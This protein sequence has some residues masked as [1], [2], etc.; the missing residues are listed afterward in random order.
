VL[1]FDSVSQL[2]TEKELTSNVG[3]QHRAPGAKLMANF[4]RQMS[5]T[6][7][8]NDSVVI[9][10]IHLIANTSGFGASKVES[11]GNKIR[12]ACDVGIRAKK[13][14]FK[15]PTSKKDAESTSPPYGQ[16]VTWITTSTAICSPGQQITSYIRYGLG[17]DDTFEIMTLATDAGLIEKKGSWYII[18]V[19]KDTVR[20]QG[21]EKMCQM[22][23]DD[24]KLCD[25]LYK[26]VKEMI[27]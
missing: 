4:C 3:D 13:F 24:K 8:V 6:V 9:S 17:I 19:G 5:N 7:P 12:F 14:T 18:Q 1:I 25:K 27:F 20:A 2:A 26:Q 16:E 22:L 21:E 11:G 15:R 23:R 10:I